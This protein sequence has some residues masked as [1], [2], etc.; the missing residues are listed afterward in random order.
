MQIK[1]L[2]YCRVSSAK[3][4]NEWNWLSSQEKRCRDYARSTLWVEVEKVFNDEWVSW[5]LFERKSIRELFN[6]IDDNKTNS[7][8]VIFEDLNRLSRDIQ[9]HSLLKA[10]FK[11]RGV[12]LAS[13]NFKFEAT[14][15]WD[16]KE[17]ISVVVAQY[18]KDKNRERV[19]NRMKAR[20]EQGYWCFRVPAGYKYIEAEW[21]WKIL[22]KDKE[23][24]K[25]IKKW[26]EAYANWRLKTSVQIIEY[27]NSK[28]LNIVD[29]KK[30]EYNESSS[31]INNML[32]NVLYTWH[33]EMPKWD[34]PLMKA[35]H[36]AIISMETYKQIQKNLKSM[37]ARTR[38]IESSMHRKDISADF[39]LR[40][41][42][43]CETSGYR[44]S[45]AWSRG[46]HKP[47]PYYTYPNKSPMRW[48]WINRDKFHPEFEKLLKKITPKKEFFS[49]FKAILKDELKNRNK[50]K[51]L[52]AKN[53]DKEINSLDKQI[54]KFIERIWVCDSEWIIKKYESQIAELEK[55]KNLKIEK[56][57]KV[58]KNVWT[59]FKTDF[60]SFENALQIWNKWSLTNKKELLKN[61]FPKGIPINDK[62]EVWTPV[63]SLVYQAFEVSKVSNSDL[64][65]RHRCSS[66]FVWSYVWK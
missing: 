23:K 50:S 63:L 44:L 57:E 25:I 51:E 42:L 59:T 17:N 33:L 27:F 4:V 16:F 43:F 14:P 13:P 47:I 36:E 28:G 46:R 20:L 52:I 37:S 34:I 1:W 3:Q 39:P 15:E 41:I 24:A 6:Y 49:A 61:I 21:G 66:N 10:E 64:V 48:K 11:K 53:L 35:K 12:E 38:Q 18:E 30:K 22:V 26:F 19:N 55:V 5:G 45:W 8:V 54:D 32:R 7:Y 58:L 2:I 65:A 56:K 31:T 9:V 62:K 40:G 29:I 60:K